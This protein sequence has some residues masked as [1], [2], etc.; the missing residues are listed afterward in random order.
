MPDYDS[1]KEIFYLD[2]LPGSMIILG[3]GPIATEM[4][5]AFCQLGTKV[6]VHLSYFLKRSKK[7]SSSFSI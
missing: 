4:A 5:Q 2:H 3:A 7:A 6:S 1:N